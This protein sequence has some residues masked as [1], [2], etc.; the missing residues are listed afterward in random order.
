MLTDEQKQQLLAIASLGCDRLTSSRYVGASVEALRGAIDADPRFAVDLVRA[1]AQAEL[2]HMKNV[3]HASQDEKNWRVS[4]WW[5]ERCR[6]ER[7]A[8]QRAGAVTE[9]DVDQLMGLIR[10]AIEEEVA[11]PAERDRVYDRLE[12]AAR[13]IDRAIEAAGGAQSPPPPLPHGAP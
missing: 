10:E 8:P 1:E 3:H 11:D 2:A 5:L 13:K 9:Q 12:L 4:V 6:P 7:Y